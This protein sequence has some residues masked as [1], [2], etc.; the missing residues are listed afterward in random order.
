MLKLRTFTRA[1]EAFD[2]GETMKH[3][4]RVTGP[5]RYGQVQ[6]G[7]VLMRQSEDLLVEWDD[8]S[9]DWFQG[10]D[11]QKLSWATGQNL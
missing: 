4:Q 9:L 1:R 3:G 2:P 5:D 6:R 8:R 11:V 7:R 10:D